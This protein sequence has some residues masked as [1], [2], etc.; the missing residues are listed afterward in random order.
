MAF[1]IEAFKE[2]FISVSKA[3]KNLESPSPS[4]SW[5]T[6]LVETGVVSMN[7]CPLLI[8]PVT[9]WP[10][11]RKVQSAKGYLKTLANSVNEVH[12]MKDSSSQSSNRQNIQHF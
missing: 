9:V 6:I 4:V 5:P 3:V 2:V 8:T 7:F 11:V 1:C 10:S 12:F